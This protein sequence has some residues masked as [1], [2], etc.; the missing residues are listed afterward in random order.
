MSVAWKGTCL[1]LSCLCNFG[2]AFMMQYNSPIILLKA[3]LVTVSDSQFVCNALYSIISNK[4][5]NTIINM[6][7][8]LKI[9]RPFDSIL[10]LVSGYHKRPFLLR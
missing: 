10:V 1:C 6:G 4:V 8:R 7:K 9:T 5:I 3:S 2:D